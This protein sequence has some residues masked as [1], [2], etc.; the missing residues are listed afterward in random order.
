MTLMAA[1][2]NEVYDRLRKVEDLS[3]RN[4]LGLKS[5]EN[6]CAIRYEALWREVRGTGR[7]L[8]WAATTLLIGMAGILTKLLF[9]TS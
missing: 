9:F 4:H 7:I 6:E 3:L 2:T 8:R 5:H 1:T